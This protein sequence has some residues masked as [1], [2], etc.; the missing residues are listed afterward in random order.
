M[1]KFL[2]KYVLTLK[3][4]L[5]IFYYFFSQISQFDPEVLD[6]SEFEEEE[7]DDFADESCDEAGA[8][9]E[10]AGAGVDEAALAAAY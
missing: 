2:I 3:S 1:I 6:E 9:A 5:R 8:A 10:D 7:L 4:Q